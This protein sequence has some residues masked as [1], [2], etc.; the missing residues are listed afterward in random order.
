MAHVRYIVDDVG[1]AVAFYVAKVGFEL[2]QK[3]GPAFAIV[4]RGDLTLWLAGIQ[5]RDRRGARGQ[6][7][8]L[9]RSLGQRSGAIPARLQG[10]VQQGDEAGR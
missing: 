1:E 9:Q 4:V 3:F 2:E 6:A 5:E 7:D 10:A 8:P